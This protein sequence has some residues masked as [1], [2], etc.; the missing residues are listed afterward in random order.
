MG[1]SYT[2]L[3]NIMN[4][5][6][7]FFRAISNLGFMNN[8]LCT[9]FHKSSY[10]QSRINTYLKNNLIKKYADGK[11]GETYYKLTTGGKNYLKE[12]KEEFN[13]KAKFYNSTSVKHDYE[14]AKIYFNSTY[15][16]QINWI[17]ETEAREIF[18]DRI[19]E[20]REQG[21][22]ELADRYYNDYHTEDNKQQKISTVDSIR[23]NYEEQ[24]Y[25][26]Y[27]IITNNYSDLQI[28]AKEEFCR[29]LNIEIVKIYV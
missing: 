20:L 2:E 12:H 5:D 8:N 27:E 22:N 18:E 14:L 23:Y 25:M 24:R 11:T 6:K 3:G 7:E 21:E 16:Q 10:S 15:E 19:N 1:K 28:E 26:A 29:V 9:K 4:K 13:I 17:N